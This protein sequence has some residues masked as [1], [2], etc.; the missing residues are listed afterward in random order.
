MFKLD[1]RAILLND[2]PPVIMKKFQDRTNQ[3]TMN[4]RINYT[5]VKNFSK[6]TGEGAI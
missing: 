4:I 3:H 1:M 6:K 5:H 2:K